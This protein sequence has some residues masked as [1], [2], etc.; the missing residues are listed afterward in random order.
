MARVAINIRWRHLLII[1]GI[2]LLFPNSA[3]SQ[4]DIFSFLK[5]E[6][7]LDESLDSIGINYI[8][9]TTEQNNLQIFCSTEYRFFPSLADS[10]HSYNFNVDSQEKVSCIVVHG[11]VDSIFFG[12]IISFL[13]K[14]SMNASYGGGFVLKWDMK[15]FRAMV[16][17]FDNREYLVIYRLNGKARDFFKFKLFN[18]EE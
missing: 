3:L 5:I 16:F 10:G 9:N 15:L 2:A 12:R 11:V 6:I 18:A 17:T 8:K 13:G 7:H 14:P 1:L 4:S